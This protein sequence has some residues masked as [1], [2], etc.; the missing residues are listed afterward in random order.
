MHI[1]KK[2]SVCINLLV[3]SPAHGCHRLG[4]IP[5]SFRKL[6][7]LITDL[8]VAGTV[9]SDLHFCPPGPGTVVSLSVVRDVS[10]SVDRVQQSNSTQYGGAITPQIPVRGIYMSPIVSFDLLYSSNSS[11]RVSPGSQQFG[12][13]PVLTPFCPRRS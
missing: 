3:S 1:L 12:K 10:Q 9:G 13:V 8:L 5:E 6:I 7:S 4:I 11:Y 2:I